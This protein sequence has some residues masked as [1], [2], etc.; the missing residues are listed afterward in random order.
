MTSNLSNNAYH[1]KKFIGSYLA[2]LNESLNSLNII[3]ISQI[4]DL[5][6]KAYLNNKRIFILG[7]GGAASTA[8]HF[9]CDL[10]KGTL[11]RIY[12]NEEKRFQVISLTDNVATI[13]AYANDLI[14]AD[15]FLQQ[16]R[17][18]V[19]KDDVVIAISGSGN[20]TNLIKAVNYAKKRGAKTIGILGFATGGALGKLVDCAIIARSKFYG[21]CEDIQLIL[22]HIIVSWLSKVKHLHDGKQIPYRKNK[23]IPFR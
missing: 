6:T 9:A 3:K 5:L 4:I 23:A 7:N 21:P 15:I 10:S 14:F 12:D 19:D 17:N 8:S 11:Q 22:G 2:E 16:L 13:T 18:L 1:L 20:S